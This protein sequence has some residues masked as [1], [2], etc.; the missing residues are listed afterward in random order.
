MIREANSVIIVLANTFEDQGMSFSEMEKHG[1]SSKGEG[2]GIGLASVKEILKNYNN[3]CKQTE[4]K[5]GY[6]IQTLIIE[7]R[8]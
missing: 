3:V 1:I 4:K 5:E 8:R 2:R 7:K 6:F